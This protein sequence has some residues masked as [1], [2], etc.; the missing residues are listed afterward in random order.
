MRPKIERLKSAS[1]A[2]LSDATSALKLMKDAW[3]AAPIMT[4]AIWGAVILHALL[5]PL[6]LWFYKAL[7][8]RLSL[9]APG[10][11]AEVWILF[12]VYICGIALVELLTPAMQAMRD[13]LAVRLQARSSMLVM[14]AVLSQP[15]LSPFED[16]A[17]YNDIQSV[18]ARLM[19]ALRVTVEYLPHTVRHFL[20]VSMMIAV[21]AAIEPRLV[22]FLVAS[23]VPAT[24]IAR[25]AESL[26]WW[27]MSQGSP[28]VR[29]MDYVRDVLLSTEHAKEVRLYGLGAFF[30]EQYDSTFWK[31]FAELLPFRRMTAW[32]GIS[33][34][35]IYALSAGAVFVVAAGRAVNSD[36]SP[37]VIAVYIGSVVQLAHSI[38]AISGVL[39]LLHEQMVVVKQYENVVNKGARF[40]LSAENG[41]RPF[42]GIRHGI[43]FRNV[44]FAYPWG[45]RRVV[46]DGVS[47]FIPAG[48]TVAIVGENGAGKS[49]IVK[50]L[51]RL[52]EPDE[53][54]ILLDGEP[55]G[56]YD[57]EDFRRGI[58]A[59]F[60]DFAKYQLSLRDNIAVGNLDFLYDD[61]ELRR[62]L[63]DAGGASLLSDLKDGFEQ[64]LGRIFTGG[65]ELSQ[66][67]WQKIA[68]ARAFTRTDAHLIILDEPTAALDVQTEYDL[69]T[70][71]AELKKGRTSLLI[72]HRFST[73]RMADII[74][75]LDKGKVI[76]TGTH[77]ELLQRGGR[78]AQL[79]S[80]QAE[81]YQ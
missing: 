23:L 11:E 40:R 79:F 45:D 32:A 4:T 61:Q 55:L 73:V 29:W 26:A 50:L 42:L 62:A 31:R 14:E 65:R 70:R 15:D 17:Y 2:F 24:F 77:E 81:R 21:L 28:L 66:G 41:A 35:I 33:L 51:C 30:R 9:G 58:T 71:L 80:M 53:G 63:T 76:E 57:L 25:R 64:Q 52:Y 44:R 13:Q 36:L 67:Q 59:V 56:A 12:A 34:G 74:I 22:A 8:D 43:E 6:M 46:L 39:T 37:G 10:N 5:V 47:F 78:Y 7:I 75:V 27:G 49:T 60:Q 54:L 16:P 19:R 18:R 68:V 72:S 3:Q 69:F 1:S 20:T 38:S 48:K